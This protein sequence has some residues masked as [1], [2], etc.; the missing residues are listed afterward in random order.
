MLIFSYFSFLHCRV[1][2]MTFKRGSLKKS[3]LFPEDEKSFYFNDYYVVLAKNVFSEI[4]NVLF[5]IM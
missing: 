3:T 2:F 5:F 1:Y 4:T